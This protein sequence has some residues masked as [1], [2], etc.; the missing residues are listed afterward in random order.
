MGDI[1]RR[2]GQMAVASSPTPTIDDYVQNGIV[3]WLDGIENTRDGHN[4]SS[5]TWH[6]LTGNRDVTYNVDAE[7]ADKYC[8]PNGKAT[9]GSRPALNSSCT[10]EIVC[11]FISNGTSQIVLPWNGNNYGTVWFG[12]GGGVYFS[13]GKNNGTKGIAPLTGINTYAARGLN[14]MSANGE[15]AEIVSA[16][17][18]WAAS[19]YTLFYYNTTYKNPCVS[20]I[21]AI[22]I[23]DRLLTDAEIAH[24]AAVDAARFKG[25]A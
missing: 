15:E 21:Y 12:S 13:A 14:S 7:I 3:F 20:K 25:G 24:N 19:Q 18:S 11:E 1:L 4:A 6:D 9:I 16:S 5:A 2:R 10:I 22:R 23:Y 17:A 8:I